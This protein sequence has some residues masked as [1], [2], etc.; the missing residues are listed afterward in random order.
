LQ[1]DPD[2]DEAESLLLNGLIDDVTPRVERALREWLREVF[3]PS[4]SEAEILDWE[5]RLVA[6]DA[7]FRDVLQRALVDASDLGVQVAVDQLSGASLGFDWTLVNTRARDNARQYAAQLVSQITETTRSN[8][9]EAVARFINN[10]EG[11]PA[12]IRDLRASGFSARRAKLIAATELTGAFAR[13]NQQAYE[14]SG[15]VEF[16]EW[17]T[18]RDERVCPICGKLYRT[19]TKIGAQFEGQYMPPA[20]PGC[21]CWVVPIIYAPDAVPP[22]G[23]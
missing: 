4:M 7:R 20:H 21:R 6:G 5:Q 9:R 2:D 18:A 22:S 19:R 11:T 13:A 10:G 17:R 16:M 1:L 8:I 3:G 23:V 12:L 14:E 15:V